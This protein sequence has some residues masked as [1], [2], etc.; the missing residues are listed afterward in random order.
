MT[1]QAAAANNFRNVVVVFLVFFLVFALMNTG[2]GFLYKPL[3]SLL[4]SVPT[5]TMLALFALIMTIIIRQNCITTVPENT[6]GVITYSN[7]GVLKTLAPPGQ[8]WVWFGREQMS[9]FLSLEPVSVQMSL[10][11]LK[12]SDGSELPPLVTI[13]TWRV[14]SSITTLLDTQYRQQVM[15]VAQGSQMK[16]E[17]WVRDTVAEVMG[18]RTARETLETLPDKLSYMLHNEFGRAVIKEVNGYLMPVGLRVERLECIGNIAP[19]T[20]TP[21]TV[22]TI[23]AIHKKLESLLRPKTPDAA[24]QAV[25]QQAE[26][27]LEQARKAVLAMRETVR[28]ADA[29][30]QATI[31]TLEQAH[32]HFKTQADIKVVSAAQKEQGDRLTVLAHEISTLLE[33]ANALKSASEQ[34]KHAPF[35][36]T[37]AEVT[38][39]LKVLEAIEQKK[40]PLG[41]LFP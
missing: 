1:R 8:A 33:A 24:L 11:G 32:Q 22:K 20:K 37:T 9:G 41:G 21:T 30:M 4:I 38:T 18:R 19:S 39:L 40:L 36:L 25:Q 2:F 5:F 7:G 13:I 3:F 17:R 23:G 35:D 12:L 28:A 14:H 29:Y 26:Q 10:L 15:E 31:T 34:I 6:V 27:I 16:R